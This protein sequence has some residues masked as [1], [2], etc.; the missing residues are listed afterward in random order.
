MR[1]QKTGN[2]E[3]E[4]V[5]GQRDEQLRKANRNVR[6]VYS[7]CDRA[8]A[9]MKPLDAVV[10]RALVTELERDLPPRHLGDMGDELGN[11][12]FLS[13][14][15]FLRRTIELAVRQMFELSEVLLESFEHR[16]PPEE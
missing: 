15:Q 3:T 1:R 10:K 12:L 6:D 5:L 7:R 4:T 16:L 13:A 11:I 9:Q 2:R 8:F 14:D